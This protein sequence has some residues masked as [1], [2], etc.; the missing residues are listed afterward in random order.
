[1]LARGPE[2]TTPPEALKKE[3]T[4]LKEKA[5]FN[6]LS[7][8]SI[9]RPLLGEERKSSFLLASSRE[10]KK[11]W[12]IFWH[13]APVRFQPAELFSEALEC[14][15]SNNWSTERKAVRMF[16]CREVLGENPY[17]VS[18]NRDLANVNLESWIP[19]IWLCPEPW[20]TGA[21]AGWGMVLFN[22]SFSQ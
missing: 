12:G 9:E 14:N 7:T 8:W 5:Q 11:I 1:M 4:I 10:E 6:F 16:S 17:I 2:Q 3:Q 18:S 20:K 21:I 19:G 15:V 13:V 22:S